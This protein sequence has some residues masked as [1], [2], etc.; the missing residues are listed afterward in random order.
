[1]F[2]TR[3][4]ALAVIAVCLSLSA[5]DAAIVTTKP[6]LANQRTA[7]NCSGDR[8]PKRVGDPIRC[9]QEG[10]RTYHIPAPNSKRLIFR[11]YDK[12]CTEANGRSTNCEGDETNQECAYGP[13][14]GKREWVVEAEKVHI[15]KPVSRPRQCGWAVEGN[16]KCIE[17]DC[18]DWPTGGKSF[19]ESFTNQTEYPGVTATC[20]F[21]RCVRGGTPT[22]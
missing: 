6:S 7:G 20:P 17:G 12:P 2:G 5:G 18:K 9:C 21:N 8:F 19:P 16:L 15:F 3:L 14:G 13:C 4:M 11:T 22:P 10:N 1:M